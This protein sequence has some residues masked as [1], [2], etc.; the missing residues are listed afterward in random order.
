MKVIVEIAEVHYSAR[1]I[2]VPDN[3]TD[4]DI[5]DLAM[6]DAGHANE[7]HLS[8]SHTLDEHEWTIRK[9]NAEK[10]PW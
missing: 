4:A 6:Q 3:A 8:Y 9:E 5:R 10:E 7:L 2:D 1:R